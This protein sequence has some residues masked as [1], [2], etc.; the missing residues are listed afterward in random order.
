MGYASKHGRS[1]KNTTHVD[2]KKTKRRYYVSR[3]LQNEYMNKWRET[4]E[5]YY[6]GE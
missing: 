1:C 5:P 3:A 6:C 4:P 2:R